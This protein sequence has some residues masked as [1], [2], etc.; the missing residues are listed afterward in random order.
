ML[1]SLV[2]GKPCYTVKRRA[3]RRNVV[4]ISPDGRTLA[5]TNGATV[6][7]SNHRIWHSALYGRLWS[8]LPVKHS[9]SCPS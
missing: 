6:H 3:R 1:W 2:E 8:R 7:L 5:V 4:A 9:P